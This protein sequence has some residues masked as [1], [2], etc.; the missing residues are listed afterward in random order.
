MNF[1]FTSNLFCVLSFSNYAVAISFNEAIAIILDSLL[2]KS[3]PGNPIG[4]M[5]IKILNLTSTSLRYLAWP[6]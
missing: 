3:H 1:V 6:W 4:Y 2:L 5:F